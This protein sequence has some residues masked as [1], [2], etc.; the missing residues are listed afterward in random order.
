MFGKIND[1]YESVKNGLEVEVNLAT[2]EQK[3]RLADAKMALADIKI[4]YADLIEENDSLKRKQNDDKN[5]HIDG[6]CY[7][8]NVDGK[9]YAI[10]P[11]CWEDEGKAIMLNGIGAGSPDCPKCKNYYDVDESKYENLQ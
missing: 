11:K 3:E 9:N 8:K 10:C 2:A 7:A 5:I 6:T 4:A 1:A